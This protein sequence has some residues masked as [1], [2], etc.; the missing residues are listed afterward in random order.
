MY[1]NRPLIIILIWYIMTSSTSLL[2]VSGIHYC[3]CCW[4][5]GQ[6]LS[7]FKQTNKN[8]KKKNIKKNN[9]LWTDTVDSGV[10]ECHKNSRVIRAAKG[11][12][13]YKPL[14]LRNIK[15]DILNDILLC[16]IKV[17][18]TLYIEIY[19]QKTDFTVLKTLF[20]V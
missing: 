8:Q 3:Y 11:F 4:D 1:K 15:L 9:Q 19:F 17:I 2:T 10:S 5:L 14:P 12:A 16:C 20:K 18:Y 6:N 13:H 7:A